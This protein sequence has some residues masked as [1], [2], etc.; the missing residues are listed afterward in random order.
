MAAVHAATTSHPLDVHPRPP[1]ATCAACTSQ[2]DGS[3]SPMGPR[4][5]GSRPQLPVPTDLALGGDSGAG[6]EHG[7]HRA[8]C[9]EPDHVVERR[10]DAASVEAVHVTVRAGDQEVEDEREAE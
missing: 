7:V 10:R 9:G 6:G 5:E 1:R 4:R 2:Y 8:E 3:A